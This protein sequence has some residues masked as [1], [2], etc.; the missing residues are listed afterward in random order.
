MNGELRDSRGR[1][2]GT[3][4]FIVKTKV[5]LRSKLRCMVPPIKESAQVGDILKSSDEL[6]TRFGYRRPVLHGNERPFQKKS[7]SKKSSSS[8]KKK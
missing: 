1:L 8:S 4:P 5:D 6:T 2:Y 3:G 7:S